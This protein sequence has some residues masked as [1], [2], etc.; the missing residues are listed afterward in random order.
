MCLYLLLFWRASNFIPVN[1]TSPIS[2][3]DVFSLEQLI[4]RIGVFG[5][6]VM[7]ILSGF[8]A[9]NN[10]YQQLAVALFPVRLEVST[11]A[12]T[13][14]FWHWIVVDMVMLGLKTRVG[15]LEYTYFIFLRRSRSLLDPQIPRPLSSWSNST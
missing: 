5:V 2:P 15:W 7:A 9:V 3:L 10:P 6:T 11:H 12:R 1:D 14:M 13:R 8:G 4:G